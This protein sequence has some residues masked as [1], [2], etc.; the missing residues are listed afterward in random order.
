[1]A[2]MK[3]GPVRLSQFRHF[4]S[5]R[6]SRETGEHRR[7]SRRR[8]GRFVLVGLCLST[9]A[10]L[11][12]L[13]ATSGASLQ[14]HR[15]HQKLAPPTII[16]AGELQFCS[17]IATPPIEYYTSSHVATG[18]D[19]ELGS[20]IARELG[21]KP[22]WL[23]VSFSGIIPDLKAHHCDAIM[24]DLYIKP[25][26]EGQVNF[27]PYM[28]ASESVVVKAG[29]PDHVTG[30]DL[31]LCGLSVATEVSTTAAEY[32]T[33]TSKACVKAGKKAIAATDFP[34]PITAL[35]QVELGRDAAMATTT[36]NAAYYMKQRP[37]TFAFAG[38]PYGEI[39][40][41]IA[42]NKGAS[43]L[44][45]AIAQAFQEVFKSGE[46]NKIFE[47]FDLAPDELAKPMADVN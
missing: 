3:G 46:Y 11:I 40:C 32:V 13:P 1:L 21:L 22:V 44:E 30:M 4:R 41:G 24:S 7:W 36:A 34:T 38:K 26:R 15:D 25:T 47:A 6:C 20:A 29:N 35:Q 8:S 39:L 5:G 45:A 37:G 23:N 2:L 19:V 33:K 31:S 9:A 43:K 12:L 14:V 16:E 42:L 27:V 18:T 28:W 17:T 10:A